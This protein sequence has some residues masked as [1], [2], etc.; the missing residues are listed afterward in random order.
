MSI[1]LLDHQQKKIRRFPGQSGL[2]TGVT[3]I[4]GEVPNIEDVLAEV[5]A[6]LKKA[7]QLQETLEPKKH[8]GCGCSG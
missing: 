8:R 5:D 2:S 4:T 1:V 7:D 3:D 6:A